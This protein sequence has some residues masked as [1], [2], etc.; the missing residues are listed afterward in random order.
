MA[1]YTY[2]GLDRR[3][4]KTVDGVTT[5]FTYDASGRMLAERTIGSDHEI[6]YI[7]LENELLAMVVCPLQPGAPKIY[8]V[9]TDHIGKPLAMTDANADIVWDAVY[10]PFGLTETMVATVDNRFRFP[11]QYYDDETGLALQLSPLLRPGI[12]E[13][14]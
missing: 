3:A 9:H 11:G 12:W 1:V 2:D 10:R 4:M 13:D 8:Y 5:V 7:H 14:I 6:A